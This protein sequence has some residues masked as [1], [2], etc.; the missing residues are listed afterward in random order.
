MTDLQTA[1]IA[2]D[3]LTRLRQEDARN[4]SDEVGKLMREKMTV[5]LQFDV[6]KGELNSLEVEKERWRQEAL[7]LRE[8]LAAMEITNVK[9]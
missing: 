8:K 3:E 7:S 9:L 4:H 2:I 1:N 5:V 6:L